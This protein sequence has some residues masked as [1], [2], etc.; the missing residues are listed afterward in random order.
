MTED[1]LRLGAAAVELAK[2]AAELRN[3]DDA[4]VAFGREEPDAHDQDDHA[5]GRA[6]CENLSVA[7]D[8]MRRAEVHYLDMRAK[9]TQAA[10][11]ANAQTGVQP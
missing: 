6:L 11:T 3:A 4:L 5:R 8:A 1:E 10:R 9:V 7:Y 2:A